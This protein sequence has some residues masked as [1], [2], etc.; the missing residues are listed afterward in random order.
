MD[1]ICALKFEILQKSICETEEEKKLQDAL[2]VDYTSGYYCDLPEDTIALIKQGKY[3]NAVM[4]DRILSDAGQE[5][6][7]LTG[8]K[9]KAPGYTAAGPY[10]LGLFEMKNEFSR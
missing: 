7:R 4:T 3:T 6:H 10:T 2:C 5:I 8:K 9:G 1:F